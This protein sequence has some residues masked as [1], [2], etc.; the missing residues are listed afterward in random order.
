MIADIFKYDNFHNTLSSHFPSINYSEFH[1]GNF[2]SNNIKSKKSIIFFVDE[3]A[4]G[5]K[6]LETELLYYFYTDQTIT[7]NTIVEIAN[8]YFDTIKTHFNF[9]ESISQD[10]YKI[11]AGVDWPTYDDFLQNKIKKNSNVYKEIDSYIKQQQELKINQYINQLKYKVEYVSELKIFLESI[12]KENTIV[13][14]ENNIVYNFLIKKGFKSIFIDVFHDIFGDIE[15]TRNLPNIKI[16]KDNF[17]Y[18]YYCLNNRFSPDRQNIIKTLNKYN[19]LDYGYITQNAQI[20]ESYSL[21]LKFNNVIYGNSLSKSFDNKEKKLCDQKNHNIYNN[22]RYSNHVKNLFF[23]NDNIKTIVALVAETSLIS[24]YI[25]EKS[26]QPFLLGKIPLIIGYTG[27]NQFLK[28]EGFDIFDDIIDYSFDSILNVDLKINIAIKT[29]QDILKNFV[30]TDDILKRLEY[31]QNY[32]LY[33]WTDKKIND[34]VKQI[35]ELLY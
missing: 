35:Q 21:N 33:S 6:E 30:I 26:V 13:L 3:P 16:R 7:D 34:I 31:N 10:T 19:L 18:N 29:N 27:L 17:D 11:L 14:V 8:R 9:N 23:I 4:V 24:R 20:N 5:F 25:T 15:S 28:N 32:L 12:D 1:S 22:V 2:T